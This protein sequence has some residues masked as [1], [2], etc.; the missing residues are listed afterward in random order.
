MRPPQPG[1]LPAP[2]IAVRLD[3][4]SK[5]FGS[6]GPVAA[7]VLDDVHLEVAAGE[8]LCLLGASG[9]GKSTLLNL[10]AGLDRPTTGTI[11]RT[12]G[13]PALMFQDHALFPWL[14]VGRNIETALR[15]A[16]VARTE[17]RERAL[18]LLRLV[19]LPDGYDL[20][21]HQLSGGMRQ[22]VALARAL[23]QGSKVLLMDE[24]FAALDAI[25]RNLLHDELL[26]VWKERELTVVFVTH[27]V[28]E[29][30][31]LGDRVVLLGSRPGRVAA[32]WDVGLARPRRPE[33]PG[34]TRLS[35]EIT[36]RLHEEIIRHAACR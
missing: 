3:H 34:V 8:F 13:R 36:G 35:R 24:P 18:D 7:P 28:V 19:R 33:D 2:G 5:R 12:S 17:R 6:A 25:N 11:H 10:V 9:S 16:G 14:S 26:R 1:L 30:V 22:R 31:R 29:A 32:T 23:A 4:V 20:R 15:L 27:D 21:V